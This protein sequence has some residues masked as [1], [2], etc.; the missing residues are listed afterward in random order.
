MNINFLRRGPSARLSANTVVGLTPAGRS[1]A[2]N[3]AEK[4]GPKYD[5]L[6]AL[7]DGEKTVGD[8]AQEVNLSTDDTRRWLLRMRG[9]VRFTAD[10]V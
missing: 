7:Q 10:V 3:Y 4:V 9:N 6:I 2:D 1:R 5:I 8:L